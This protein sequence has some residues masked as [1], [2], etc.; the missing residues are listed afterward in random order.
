MPSGTAPGCRN[1]HS[2]LPVDGGDGGF[3]WSSATSSIYGLDLNSYSQYLN[4]SFSDY[5][6]HGFQLRCLSE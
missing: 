5:R 1:A 2:G 4:A 3:S 6:A